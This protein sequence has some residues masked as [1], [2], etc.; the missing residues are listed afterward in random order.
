MAGVGL[1]RQVV[2]ATGE[3]FWFF[4]SGVACFFFKKQA[5][6]FLIPGG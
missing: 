6:T 5:E 1:G 2:L 3:S 4:V